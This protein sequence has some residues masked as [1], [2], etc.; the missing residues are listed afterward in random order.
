MLFHERESELVFLPLKVLA[1]VN[2]PIKP[3]AITLDTLLPPDLFWANI[4]KK[5]RKK[6]LQFNNLNKFPTNCDLVALQ[7]G[8]TSIKCKS[9]Q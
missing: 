8:T 1:G 2:N 9:F 6:K 7:S 3:F 5:E 4:D